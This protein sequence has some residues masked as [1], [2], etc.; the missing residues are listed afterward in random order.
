MALPIGTLYYVP[1]TVNHLKVSSSLS[2]YSYAIE[3]SSKLAA[4]AIFKGFISTESNIAVYDPDSDTVRPR[5]VYLDLS[6][7]KLVIYF[8]GSTST[9]ADKIFYICVGPSVSQ[10]NNADA[11]ENSGYDYVWPFKEFTNGPTTD[12]PT[13]LYDL[14]VVNP[15]S[16]GNY[17][18]FGASGGNTGA[19]GKHIYMNPAHIVLPSGSSKSIEFLVYINDY[20]QNNWGKLIAAWPFHIS[21]YN[22]AP[23]TLLC[24]NDGWVTYVAFPITFNAWH[25]VIYVRE[26]RGLAW[27]YIDGV[28]S[29]IQAMNAPLNNDNFY[30]LGEWNEYAFNGFTSDIGIIN[31]E[32]NVSLA[33][34][35]SNMF[36][37]QATFWTIG[38]GVNVQY[39]TA[40]FSADTL[41]VNVGDNVNFT[42]LSTGYPAI[43]EWDW[44]L[45]DSF[46]SSEQ[47]PTQSW[48]IVG[49]KTISLT[50]T[51]D[52]GLDTETKTDYINVWL[53][54]ANFTADKATPYQN[55]EV[56]FTDLTE[57]S[58]TI[59][60]WDWD[61]G[62]GTPHSSE[63]NPIHSYSS[64]GYKTVTLTV[65]SV[66]GTDIETKVNCINVLEF[67]SGFSKI[68]FI[69]STAS[70]S[71]DPPIFG[72]TTN[73]KFPFE[74]VPIECG[75]FALYDMGVGAAAFN[76]YDKR[77]CICDFELTKQES[78]SLNDFLRSTRNEA[79]S[80][81]VP[82][83]S[84]FYP[85]GPDKGDCGTFST[86]VERIKHKGM[87]NEPFRYFG[88]QLRLQFNACCSA[89]L[90]AQVP[91]GTF[92]IG[93]ITDLR[94]PDDMFDPDHT[95]AYYP[96]LTEGSTAK[97]VDRGSLSDVRLTQ[98]TM[99]CNI[100]K[101][102]ALINHIYTTIR[103][104][105]TSIVCQPEH[106]PFGIND[107]DNQTFDAFMIQDT[108][109][110]KHN[111]F[112]EFEMKL[113]FL[114]EKHISPSGSWFYEASSEFLS[115]NNDGIQV[116]Q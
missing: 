14:T 92:Q 59:I 7:N 116:W 115:H 58:G 95:F 37:G 111:R 43:D 21:V 38:T 105:Q 27:V 86:V 113:R 54:D 39:I 48:D 93:S 61:L 36:M 31:D 42:D 97:F 67:V 50:V 40:D 104:N 28:A 55:Q 30:V 9:S 3:L 52:F 17:C 11:W 29:G 112:N 24:T 41:S 90:P 33:Q 106:Y 74:Y 85:M 44:D 75:T 91:D 87:L 32:V 99:R 56:Q 71:I 72:Y 82:R 1:V 19:G 16:I 60:S 45:D 35:R 98:F 83:N 8:D 94:F 78:A 2:Y 62:D 100:S 114:L 79:V 66:D 108:I 34:T 51:N 101:A 64:I 20:G 73:I 18:P 47:N 5:T 84:G 68:T 46:S 49:P 102:A 57:H 103:T 80:L 6:L 65:T 23:N 81:I 63:Q 53:L 22:F 107:G 110:I 12:E 13:H 76:M 109:S 88:D 77:E 70:I 96:Q 69:S 26:Y 4:D 10:A 15:A 25:H 89:S